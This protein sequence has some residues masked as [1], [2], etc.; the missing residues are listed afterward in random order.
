MADWLSISGR[1]SA[2]LTLDAAD[3]D[4]T[5]LRS[6]LATA[7]ELAAAETS[8]D[9]SAVTTLV[10]D[11]V[12]RLADDEVACTVLDTFVAQRPSWLH[13]VLL[14]RR[15]PPLRVGRL[16]ASG[17]FADVDFGA[18][19]F[20]EEEAALLL[21]RLCSDLRPDDLAG[22]VARADG[23]AAAL[24]LSALAILS[25][26]FTAA[27]PPAVAPVPDGDKDGTPVP[28]ERLVEEY[29]W[30][31]VLES[32]R[33]ELVGLLL[34]AS[35]VGRINYGLAEALTERPDAGD[36]LEEAEAAGLFLT[37][38]PDGW[39]EVH[40]LVRD[41]LIARLWR[42]WPDGLLK[43]HAR[44]A[45][46][47][48]TRGDEL[49]AL[50]HWLA[51][52]R[53]SDAL[54][55]LSEVSLP[56]V[57]AG[58]GARA[59]DALDHIAADT[60]SRDPVDAVRFAWCQ[61]PAGPN[62]LQDALTTAESTAGSL[63]EPEPSRL[64]TL[65]AA[66]S[67]LRA[68]WHHAVAEARRALDASGG[69]AGAD[70]IDRFCWRM[71]ACGIAVDERWND[72]LPVIGQA[73][74]ASLAEA[75]GRWVLEGSRAVGLALAGHPLDAARVADGLRGRADTYEAV[76]TRLALADAL[77]ARELDQRAD[78][79]TALEALAGTS[80]YP[81]P[82]LQLVAQVELVRLRM[83]SGDL[84]A[85]A[86]QL[87][88]A[89]RLHARLASATGD[90]SSLGSSDAGPSDLIAR[91]GVELALATDVPATALD[92][93]ER[94]SDPF[95]S[96]VCRARIDLALGRHAEAEQAVRRARTRCVRHQVVAGL[97]LGQA[98]AP[99]DRTAAAQEVARTLALAARHAMLR[100]VASEGAPLMELIELAAWRVPEPWMDRLRHALVPTWTGHDAERPIDDLTDRERDVLRLL[101]SRLTLSEIAAELYVSQN[102]LKFHLRAIYR[103]LGVESRS[104]AVD[105]ARR[106][107]LLPRG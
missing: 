10:I 81:D 59:V 104:Q 42:R 26:R 45:Q 16:R 77:V 103:K 25:R 87:D 75:S 99:R 97:L 100:T 64:R 4:A 37:A 40:S 17:D 105:S 69:M 29:V 71:I 61:L 80:T 36:L 86:R 54:R 7:L 14:S 68:D 41:L 57:D 2:W 91:A 38:L 73:R 22:A 101:P 78:A 46:W 76:R 88:E 33:P 95:W 31:E 12:D 93:S 92:W 28:S 13:L 8:A 60:A 5:E 67:W 55:V 15:R 6:S 89:D 85:A 70:P 47:F 72:R 32:E 23:W 62:A 39:F 63:P 9:A 74:A 58:N 51:A 79:R 90:A 53:A 106:M 102:T 19:R 84:S 3:R 49:A 11:D 44:A 35:V 107:R 48:E 83:S 56:L 94:V 24:Q 96:P 1:R 43:Q 65:R 34:S 66:T 82:V 98:L 30:E 21:A 50:D 27:S 52:E 20:S 18:L